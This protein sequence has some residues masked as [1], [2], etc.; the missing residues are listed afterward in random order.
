MFLVIFTCIPLAWLFL[1]T[2]LYLNFSQSISFAAL[3]GSNILFW[4]EASYFAPSA[5]YV[6]LIHTWSLAVEEQYYILFPLFLMFI[7]KLGKKWSI[8][9]LSI[10]AIASFI[11]AKNNSLTKPL[12]AFY[13]LQSRAFEILIG[14]ITA[15]L[16][17]L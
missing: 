6:P 3:F 4:R 10:I 17:K 15:L 8:F 16:F 13:M 11:I 2:D 12:F 9:L 14:S 1:P 7:W 5:Q